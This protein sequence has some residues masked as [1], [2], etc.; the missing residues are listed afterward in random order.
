MSAKLLCGD[1]YKTLIFGSCW[2]SPAFVEEL[3]LN[4]S[5]SLVELA[6]TSG[7]AW[8]ISPRAMCKHLP[9]DNKGD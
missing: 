8:Y 9:F 5:R 7:Q 2:S 3:T 4:P 6:Y 1:I